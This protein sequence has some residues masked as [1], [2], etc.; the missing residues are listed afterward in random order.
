[1]AQLKNYLFVG[2]RLRQRKINLRKVDARG[3]PSIQLSD[4]DIVILVFHVQ[5]IEVQIRRSLN[6]DCSL[7]AHW[8]ANTSFV[9]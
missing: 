4:V 1:M 6:N 9:K 8:A 2:Q 3:N 5:T 7:K